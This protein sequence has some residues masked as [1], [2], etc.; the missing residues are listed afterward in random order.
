MA[1]P[2]EGGTT[3]KLVGTGF[4][5]R[6]D[7]NAKWGVYS[8]D[9]F[10]KISVRDYVFTEEGWGNLLQGTQIWSAYTRET[11]SIEIVDAHINEG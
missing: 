11:Y 9:Q 10:N 4:L 3:V 7:I 2:V 6:G 8:T 5:S 1:G